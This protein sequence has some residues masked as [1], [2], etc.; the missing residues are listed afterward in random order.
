MPVSVP[1]LPPLPISPISPRWDSLFH[2][3]LPT[4]HDSSSV[5]DRSVSME[6]NPRIPSVARSQTSAFPGLSS[7]PFAGDHPGP[8]PLSPTIRNFSLLDSTAGGYYRPITP[9]SSTTKSFT[10]NSSARDGP[11]GIENFSRPRKPSLRQGSSEPVIPRQRTGTLPEG[12]LPESDEFTAADQHQS[13]AS[14][15][16]VTQ[17]SG[18][19]RSRGYSA[20]SAISTNI[21]TS[22]AHRP[23]VDQLGGTSRT[24][25]V[26]RGIN[27]NNMGRQPLAHNEGSAPPTPREPP[28]WVTAGNDELRSSFRSQL[29][30]STALGTVFTVN[31][32]ERSS[33]LTK[34]SSV[35]ESLVIDGYARASVA[36]EDGLSV[37][38]VMGM[39]ADGF[40][41]DSDEDDTVEMDKDGSE[42]GNNNDR[43]DF[44][45]GRAQTHEED[46]KARP[47][48]GDSKKGRVVD[49]MLEV[50]SDPLPIPG[51]AAGQS[52]GLVI[53][54]DS[55]AF[56]RNSG[57]PSSLPQEV[58]FA[59]ASKRF[60]IRAVNSVDDFSTSSTPRAG[61]AS[62]TLQSEQWMP[63]GG[64][65]A[66]SSGQSDFLE[67]QISNPRNL[68]SRPSSR[69]PTPVSTSQ[70]PQEPEEDPSSR[71]RYG[72]RKANQ[73]ITREQYD[74]WDASYSEYLAR[75]R[76]KWVAYLKDSS[77]MTDHPDRF[78]QRSAK[79]KRFVRKGIPPDWRGAAWFYYAGG[80]KI[81]AKHPGV[82]DEMVRGAGLEPSGAGKAVPDKCALKPIIVEDIEKDLHRTFPDNVRFRPPRTTTEGVS[83]GTETDSEPEIISSL[84]RVLHA[85]AMYN[86]RIG[87]CQSL[88]FLAG[89]LLLFVESEEHAF[90]LLNVIT[91]VYLPGTHEMSLEGSKVD[92]GVL[93]ATLK[94]ALPSVWKQIG[95]D[96]SEMAKPGP[97]K[98]KVKRFRDISNPA[99]KTAPA[100]PNHLPAITLCMTAWFMSCFIG[101][102]PIETVLRVWDVFFYE[103][104]RTLFR[105]ALT[106]F[107]AGEAE[108]KAVTDPMEMFGVVQTL[109]RRMLDPN[110]LLEAC[111]RKRNN[112]KHLSQDVVEDKR[113]ER[114]DAIQKWKAA[115]DT[116]DNTAGP[117]TIATK[118]GLSEQAAAGLDLAADT[119]DV[120][121]IEVRR[122][123]TIFGKRKVHLD[124]ER[125]RAE[126]VL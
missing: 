99:G 50:M 98:A 22:V 55:G 49:Q 3:N 10:D 19:D 105:I 116:D 118:D 60:S 111:Y 84:R 8:P 108:I 107:K 25:S 12:V 83:N 33:V 67:S 91:R 37:E 89:L 82:Y 66:K 1:Q 16:P 78:P 39:Y 34:A 48:T 76:K 18:W 79:T 59:S 71:D 101:T 61:F 40:H 102:L 14:L 6:S 70:L 26:R 54:R 114:R 93:M 97:K 64:M 86:P 80:P 100:D 9:S 35:T 47:G 110:V 88:N 52:S 62:S 74:T 21:H 115:Q 24:A 85:F 36:E 75:R 38:D 109:P 73:Y 117:A 20:S 106:I 31:G 69:A 81:L 44:G 13:H 121:A 17:H 2:P 72:F 27:S 68:D 77:L 28:P 58:G 23:S 126:D 5:S 119:T 125:A 41:D 122:K 90:W 124:K 103:G 7:H 4:R 56:F 87:Y 32:T 113:Q 43:Q 15:N 96:D 95:G 46:A 120:D 57:L 29:T 94:D 112:F 63:N 53:A 65:L 11:V 92:L 51:A 104:S 42:D 30:A 123:G 45:P